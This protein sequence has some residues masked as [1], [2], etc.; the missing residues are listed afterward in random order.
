MEATRFAL[1]CHECSKRT[2]PYVVLADD[3]P[4]R[5][6]CSDCGSDFVEEIEENVEEIRSPTTAMMAFSP[7]MRSPSPSS[8]VSFPSQLGR[9]P[10]RSPL[11]GTEVA[12]PHERIRFHP[13]EH[14][15]GRSGNHPGQGMNSLFSD[16][17]DGEA[18]LDRFLTEIS[19]ELTL[20][21]TASQQLRSARAREIIS[22]NSGGEADHSES[23]SLVRCL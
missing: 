2:S 22:R 18:G 23:H 15:Q 4:N 10:T 8:N 3:G 7:E 12:G 5:T 1:W 20:L 17:E 13:L 16:F 21:E 9:N 6:L 19:S 14:Q 11:D